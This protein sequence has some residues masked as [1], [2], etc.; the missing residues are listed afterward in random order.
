MKTVRFTWFPLWKCCCADHTAFSGLPPSLTALSCSGFRCLS[1]SLNTGGSQCFSLSRP[2]VSLFTCRSPG[3]TPPGLW[4]GSCPDADESRVC[5]FSLY[6][7]LSSRLDVLTY[8]ISTRIFLLNASK[9]SF[10]FYS[11][12]IPHPLAPSL[13]NGIPLYFADHYET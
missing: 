10:L 1:L 11:V 4:I 9:C 12:T 3:A 6:L 7:I 8:W 13:L 5:A 2:P